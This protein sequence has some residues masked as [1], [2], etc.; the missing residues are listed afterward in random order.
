MLCQYKKVFL[1]LYF[2]GVW[3]KGVQ[4]LLSERGWTLL[5]LYDKCIIVT[6]LEILRLLT[7]QNAH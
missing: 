6:V 3:K 7:V 4:N 2:F 5:D 1:Y